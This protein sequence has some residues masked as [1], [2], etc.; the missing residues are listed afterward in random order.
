MYINMNHLSIFFGNSL[1]ILVGPTGIFWGELELVWKTQAHCA[2]GLA[3]FS[4][5]GCLENG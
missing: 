5:G 4:H 1:E 3:N 2:D